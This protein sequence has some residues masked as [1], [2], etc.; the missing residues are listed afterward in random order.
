[1]T[2]ASDP[3]S[4]SVG[5]WRQ[6]GTRSLVTLWTASVGT[7]RWLARRWRR[8][9][10]Y[11]QDQEPYPAPYP[12]PAPPG[13]LTEQR[14]P[15]APITVPA[16]GYVFNFHVRA[17]FT[18]SSEGLRPEVLSWYA[19]YFLPQAIERLTRLAAE[20]ARDV[21]PH[22]AGDLEVTLQ[23]ALAERGPWRFERG[24]VAVTCEPGAWVRLDPRVRQALQPHWKRRIALECQYDEQLRRA[25][26]A[27]RLSRRWVA[28]LNEHLDSPV[29]GGAT[30]DQDLTDALRHMMSLQQAA[31]QWVEDLLR[32]RLSN[33]SIFEPL[34]SLDILPGGSQGQAEEA[35]KRPTAPTAAHGSTGASDRPRQG[36]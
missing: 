7:G 29:T 15:P 28:I 27:E 16:R 23:Q 19:Q 32:D 25:Q 21:A 4:T 10:A 31:V 2:D 35:S 36:G 22:Q 30:E 12:P 8:L 24:D 5:R 6:R 34:T 33:D 20:R 9:V 11:L 17:T 3:E 1:M 18:W 14:D 26:Y 13:R